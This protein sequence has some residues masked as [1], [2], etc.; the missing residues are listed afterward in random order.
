ML[1]KVNIK[2]LVWIEKGIFFI[3]EQ[4]GSGGSVC[5]SFIGNRHFF[6]CFFIM[7]ILVVNAYIKQ[8]NDDRGYLL[9]ETVFLS[10]SIE[11]IFEMQEVLL[12]WYPS[13]MATMP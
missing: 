9:M 3:A 1:D 8:C 2:Y 4:V 13:I 12:C 5:F 10:I 11:N 6:I 7:R